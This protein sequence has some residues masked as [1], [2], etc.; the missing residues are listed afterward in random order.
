[1][2]GELLFGAEK[3]RQRKK[4]LQLLQEFK[5]FIPVLPIPESADKTYGTIRALLESKGEAIGITIYGLPH[6]PKRQLS[7]L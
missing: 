6:M 1:M 3:S 5:T 7:Q 4:V 2:W